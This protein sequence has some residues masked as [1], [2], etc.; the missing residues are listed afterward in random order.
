MSP[1]PTQRAG[2]T[3]VSRASTVG[4]PSIASAN[5]VGVSS[6]WQAQVGTPN[7]AGATMPLG[8]VPEEVAGSL[9]AWL[10]SPRLT[11]CTRGASDG[12]ASPAS[13]HSAAHQLAAYPPEP[14]EHEMT[15]E[16]QGVHH[17]LSRGQQDLGGVHSRLV[18]QLGLTLGDP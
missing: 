4:L 6:L 2:A 18:S 16:P 1:P 10:C 9:P 5:A 11:G 7:D 14:P 3:A 12:A 8:K 15:Q 17:L 13:G